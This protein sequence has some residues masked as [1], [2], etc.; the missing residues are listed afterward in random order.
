MVVILSLRCSESKYGGGNIIII[1][2][3]E[4][5]FNFTMEVTFLKVKRLHIGL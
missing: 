3:I 4:P 1:I 2:I 5:K